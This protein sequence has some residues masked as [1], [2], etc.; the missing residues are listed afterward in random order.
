M[1]EKWRCRLFWGN[2]HTSPPD[3]MPRI[4]MAILCDRP[5]PIPS[6]ITQMIRPGADYQPG[7]GWTIGWERIDQ[8][9]I[10]RWS[11]EARARVRQNNLRRRIEKKFPLFAEDFIAD[12]L[13]RRPQYYAGSN[14]HRP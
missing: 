9:P 5:H 8:R 14:D 7:S 13:A 2:P 6:E 1:S 10:R 11:Q 12:E 3:G 4:V